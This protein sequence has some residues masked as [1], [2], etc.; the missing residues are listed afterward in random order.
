VRQSWGEMAQLA[1]PACVMKCLESWTFSGVLLIAGLLPDATV[2][3]AAISVSFNCYGLLYMPFSSF[4]M[5]VC[6]R[7]ASFVLLVS[8]NTTSLPGIQASS[9]RYPKPIISLNGERKTKRMLCQAAAGQ[10]C[11]VHVCSYCMAAR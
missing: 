3:V 6:T 10:A 5:A 7:C 11:L 2:A 4:G 8:T 9:T 1:Y